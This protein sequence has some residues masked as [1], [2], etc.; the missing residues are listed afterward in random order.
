MKILSKRSIVLFPLLLLYLWTGGMPFLGRG[1]DLR[2]FNPV[3]LGKQEA[4]MWR[5]YYEGRRFKL[6]NQ[7]AKTLRVQFHAPYLKSY[8]L[9]MRAS[10]AAL[11][12]QKG[13]NR[14]DYAKA[15]PHLEKYYAGIK[16]VSGRSFEVESI[17]KRELEWWTIRRE[18]EKHPPA[19]WV[20][21]IA[22]IAAEVYAIPQQST[23]PHAE[24]RVEAMLM[25][26]A[27]GDSVTEEDWEAIEEILIESWTALFD[28]V[29]VERGR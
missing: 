18:R 4:N 5:Y 14:K 13:Q 2:A 27:K 25:R 10:R 22:A 23:K 26:D 21:E 16:K 20:T 7:L 28:A 29:H 11:I 3:V 17:A 1:S 12:F 9:A 8:S 6:F 24:K 15:L 19:D